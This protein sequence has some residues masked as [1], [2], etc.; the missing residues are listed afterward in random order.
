M[1]DSQLLGATIEIARS[2]VDDLAPI[3]QASF[4]PRPVD[5]HRWHYG[6]PT[7]PAMHIRS[8]YTTGNDSF[9]LALLGLR[10]NASAAAL[11]PIR[12]LYETLA[13]VRWLTE[14]GPVEQRER[15]LAITRRSIRWVE[16]TYP[17][18]LEQLDETTDIEPLRRRLRN[19]PSAAML[20][21]LA[22]IAR[23]DGIRN[24][25]EMPPRRDLFNKYMADAGGYLMFRVLSTMA[26]HPGALQ[27][28]LFYGA[29]GV[30]LDYDFKGLHLQRAY[31]LADATAIHLDLC[32]R[33]GPV[34]GWRGAEPLLGQLEAS[35]SPLGSE[36]QARL[37][38]RKIDE[39]T[40]PGPLG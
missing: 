28:G 2:L 17:H 14:P 30:G 35:L 26:S 34:C 20:K 16:D 9:S 36:I 40:N 10:A 37:R 11:G 19:P 12:H 24:D 33:C 23:E 18:A 13:I 32:R 6:M 22:D 5:D 29:P 7:I 25:V 4:D 3:H 38:A 27:S 31:W 1:S 39:L 15:A 8:F 21:D